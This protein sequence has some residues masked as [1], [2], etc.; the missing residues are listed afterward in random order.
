MS[1]DELINAPD[2]RAKG[3]VDGSDIVVAVVD[4]G[5]NANHDAFLS[6]DRTTS[7]VL[8]GQNFSTTGGA[9]N[10]GDAHGH[11]TANSAIIAG[12]LPLDGIAPGAK[13]LPLKIMVSPSDSDFTLVLKALSWLLDGLKDNKASVVCLSIGDGRCYTSFDGVPAEEKVKHDIADAI[14]ELRTKNVPTVAATANNYFSNGSKTGMCFPA[15]MKEC[16]SVGSVFNANLLTPE[17]FIQYGGAKIER[18]FIRQVTPF[19]Q[20][21]PRKSGNPHYTRLLA[22][23]GPITSAWIPGSAV[24]SDLYGSSLAAPFVV[25]TIALMQQWH[26]RKHGGLPS[27]NDLESWLLNKTDDILDNAGNDDNVVNTGA[28][29]KLLDTLAAMTAM[30]EAT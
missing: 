27:C 16:V 14:S 1:A 4:T 22:P 12:G 21:L 29:F 15:I 9:T 25:G 24:E 17:T 28:P 30:I 26:K 10:T 20:R 18:A 13:I 19:T 6:Q 5:C 3:Q 11:G 7:R 2:A 8:A 23:G